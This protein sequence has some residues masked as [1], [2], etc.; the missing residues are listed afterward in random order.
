M[1]LIPHKN[2]K[3][4]IKCTV[5]ETMY[6]QVY[7]CFPYVNINIKIAHNMYKIRVYLIMYHC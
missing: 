2:S 3:N 7:G 4:L 1:F 6:K 5:S